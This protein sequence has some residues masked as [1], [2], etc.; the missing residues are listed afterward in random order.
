MALVIKLM[1]LNSQ[2]LH[3]YSILKLTLII[4]ICHVLWKHPHPR[5]LKANIRIS[6][7]EK[8]TS[9]PSLVNIGSKC[10]CR[11]IKVEFCN[12]LLGIDNLKL[13]KPC[14]RAYA[15]N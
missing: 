3:E 6:E 5:I 14:G 9:G 10:I 7:W 13:L 15:N 4:N 8:P 11:Q 12:N 1:L 2:P